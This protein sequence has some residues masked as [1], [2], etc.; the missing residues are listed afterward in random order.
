MTLIQKLDRTLSELNIMFYPG[1]CQG[2][3][4]DYGIYEGI[5]ESP[6]ISADNEAQ[7][8]ICECNVHLFVKSK[9]SQKKRKLLKLLKNADFT[10]GDV[11][12]QYEAETN[13]T[14]YIAEVSALS[15]D[16]ETEE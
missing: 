6:E 14:H 3:G 16:Y 2:N 11:Y 1:Y 12:E 8:T 9:Q 7:I 5:V 13:Y 15:E 10:V 4:E